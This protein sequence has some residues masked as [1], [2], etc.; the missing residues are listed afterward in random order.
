[1]NWSNVWVL[2]RRYLKLGPRSPVVL[3]ALILPVFFTFLFT[4]VFGS[5]FQPEPRLGIIDLGSSQVT[6]AAQ[7][8]EG[9]D[10]R[11]YDDVDRMLTDVQQNDLDAGLVLPAG[12]DDAVRA[13]AQPPLELSL[14]GE[15]LA[16][17]RIVIAVTALDLIRGVAGVEDP[18]RVEVVT[19][20]DEQ[21]DLSVRMLPFIVMFTVAI[22]GAFVPASSLVE[23]KERHTLDAVLA[24]PA[25]ISEVL[26]AKGI[27]G[28]VL[29]V[30]TGTITLLL[31]DAFGPAPAVLIVGLV[32]GAVMM[33]EVGL[34]AGSMAPDTNTLF[35]VWKG[36]AIVLIFPVI[37]TIWPDLPQWIAKLG[38]T[39]YFLDPI[40][41]VS[42]G[43]A[44][45]SEVW[46]ELGVAALICVALVPVV[47]LSGRR[48]EHRLASGRIEKKQADEEL[49][50][51]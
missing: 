3:W 6:S 23:E 14:A 42:T 27:F 9:F 19:L 50:E 24:T 16:S 31:N 11:L 18:V 21:L 15:S 17:N 40:F 37:F 22:A 51:V 43:L 30:L 38:P 4:L 46:W 41:R 48:L 2:L 12:F 7:E 39:F 1:M 44:G 5:L 45:P 25:S 34:V 26:T 32:V 47:M 49:V 35:A 29:G 10:V 8:L 28:V 33:A 20:G 13:G 36:G